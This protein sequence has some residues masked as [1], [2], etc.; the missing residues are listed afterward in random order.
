MQIEMPNGKIHD[1]PIT[2]LLFH[3]LHP[4]PRDIEEMIRHLY[5]IDPSLLNSLGLKPFDW[6]TG[7]DL[8]EGRRRL[9][10]LLNKAL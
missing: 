7:K 1:N 3:G 5:E 9:Q 10:E 8:D 4:F 2:D 6:E